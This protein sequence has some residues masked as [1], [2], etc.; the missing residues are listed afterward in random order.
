MLILGGGWQEAL[1]A[2]LRSTL[3]KVKGEQLKPNA[4]E[5]KKPSGSRQEKKRQCRHTRLTCILYIQPVRLQKYVFAVKACA[6]FKWNRR[7]IPALGLF[8]LPEQRKHMGSKE[9]EKL[10]CP[11]FV[12]LRCRSPH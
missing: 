6:K 3:P 7:G 12:P 2:A 1:F 4:L 8:S 11:D 10:P 9:W 5:K